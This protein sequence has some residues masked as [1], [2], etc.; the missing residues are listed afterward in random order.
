MTQ[1][2]S[3][4]MV[5]YPSFGG[6][7]VVAREL[8]VGLVER[9]HTVTLVASDV[10]S[11][12]LPAHERLHFHKVDVPRYPV[13]EHAPYTLA[14]ASSLIELARKQTIELVHVHYAVP[15]AASA[16]LAI[17]ALGNKGPALVTT[18]HGTDVTGSGADPSYAPITRFAVHGSDAI[19]VPSA[20]LA[21]KARA[22]LAG[23]AALPGRDAGP[24]VLEVVPNFVDTEVFGPPSVR[25]PRVLDEL[26]TTSEPATP[27]LFH[28]SNFRAIKRVGDLLEVLERV[29]H[30]RP[31]RL[32]VVGDGPE[33]AAAEQ[34]T[35]ELGLTESVRFL[36][37]Q[38]TFTELLKHADAFMLTSELESFGLAA[39]EAM[40]CG[41][42]VLGYHVGGLPE[43]V[44]EDSGVLVP[45]FDLDALASATVE[46]LSNA[47]R[48]GQLARGARARALATFQREPAIDRYETVFQRALRRSA[49]G[50]NR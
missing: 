25:T 12:P 41:V 11:R 28:V 48:R 38:A 49:R 2:L 33:R 47:A 4:A 29:R 16:L 20:Y 21:Q 40:S 14:V 32:V 44:S 31:V 34:K 36:G 5:C 19:T 42:P 39:L 17:Q 26:F 24:P 1:P 46:L 43:V 18:L 15:H 30:T 45:A 50:A 35:R 9:G 37:K 13:F 22:W 6:S 7:G 10:L 8:A 3:I 23:D 27:I